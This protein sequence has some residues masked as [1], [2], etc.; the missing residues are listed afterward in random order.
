MKVIE[1][2][3]HRS[4]LYFSLSTESMHSSMSLLK[5]AFLL[6]ILRGCKDHALHMVLFTAQA[7]DINMA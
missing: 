6:F 1:T 2:G 5:E 3:C 7:T 4:L